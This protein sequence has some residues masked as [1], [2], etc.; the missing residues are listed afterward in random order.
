MTDTPE[1][2]AFRGPWCT[3]CG[4]AAVEYALT[5]D[6]RR[7]IGYCRRGEAMHTRADQV[8]A[9][10]RH[11]AIPVDKYGKPSGC[12]RVIATYTLTEAEDAYRTRRRKLTEARHSRHD[13]D[14]P[15]K[16]AN[17]CG[18]CDR[19]QAEL[20]HIRQATQPGR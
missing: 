12:G 1:P 14:Q 5:L 18:P 10:R 19:R 13:P 17:W 9:S 15:G 3:V 4:H 6:P 20:S 16:W 7:P 11:P 2:A 8:E